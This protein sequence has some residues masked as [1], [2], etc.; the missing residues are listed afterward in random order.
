MDHSEVLKAKLGENYKRLTALKNPKVEQFVSEFVEHCNPDRVW[1]C[2]DSKEDFNLIREMS[3]VRGEETKLATE[4]HTYHFEGYNDQGRDTRAT[5]YLLP[6]GWNLGELKSVPKKEGLQEVRGYLKDAMVGKD[7]IVMFLSLG[8]SGGK[9]SLPCVQITDSYYVAHS[10]LL[11]YRPAY[12]LFKSLGKKAGFFRFVHSAGELVGGVSKNTDKRRV[13]IDLEENIVY[14]SNTQYAGNT[15]GLKKLALRLAI[16]KA[17]GEDWLAE[18]MFLMGC[19]GPKKRITYFS[20]AFP[21]ACGKTSTA[22]MKDETIVGDDIAYLRVIGGQVRAVNVEKGIFGIIADINSKD[23]AVIF[24]AL[25]SPR[26]VIFSNALVTEDKGVYWTG[27]D[28]ECPQKGLNFSGQWFKGKKDEEGKD[29]P[30]SHKNSRYTISLYELDNIDPNMDDPKGVKL[31]GIVYGG[32]DS[33]TSVPVT[34]SFDWKHGILTMGA[35]IESETT[36][37]TL[38]Q[39]GVRR[40]DPMSNIDFVSVPLGKYVKANLDFGKRAKKPPKI[41]AVN[42]FLRNKEGK[43]LNDKN[44]KR[45]WMKWMELRVHGD[46]DAIKTPLGNIPL[47]EDLKKLFKDVLWKDYTKEEYNEQFTIRVLE[48]LA[49]VDRIEV[50]YREKVPDAPKT[51]FKALDDQRK[52]LEKARAKLGDYILPDQF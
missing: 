8:P 31:D 1:V 33:D 30:P 17:T 41:F 16:Q 40:F 26:E 18:H 7:M 39:E 38:G 52:R 5:R 14:S 51:L 10:E 19:H 23:D 43:Y 42:Y 25:T 45:V 12:K 47:Y 4:G 11:L 9:F 34:E 20:G 24:K 35:A 32:R 15:V 36:A 22:M 49:K 29:I 6:D 21:S 50:I 37:A 28:G 44:D 48:H 13:Y 2:T 27:R 46:V 3:I